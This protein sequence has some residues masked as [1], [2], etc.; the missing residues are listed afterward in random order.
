[1]STPAIL[2]F[3]GGEEVQMSS[4]AIYGADISPCLVSPDYGG[5][6]V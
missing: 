4:H 6:H 1:M 3:L 5:K 2:F